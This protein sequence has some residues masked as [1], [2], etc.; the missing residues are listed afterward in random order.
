MIKNVTG[1]A[2]IGSALHR[3]VLCARL[4]DKLVSDY[5]KL[6]TLY[7]KPLMSYPYFGNIDTVSLHVL[8]SMASAIYSST[9][10]LSRHYNSEK[11]LTGVI[12]DGNY[13][14]TYMDWKYTL[15]GKT[16]AATYIKEP[17][18]EATEIELTENDM[19]YE[20]LIDTNGVRYPVTKYDP[21]WNGA[22][23]T[24]L[25][26]RNW[27]N[28]NVTD[29]SGMLGQ[30]GEVNTISLINFN[31]SN[32]TNMATMFARCLWLVTL[33]ISS[34]DTSNVVFKEDIFLENNELTT[35]IANVENIKEIV[36]KIP[37]WTTV[38]APS[39]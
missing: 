32:V 28:R 35:V 17:P 26:I 1:S 4:I 3:K 6:A 25:T 27:T 11:T 15:Y 14:F 37:T 23:I 10:E 20:S 30:L 34:F 29:M 24:T 5:N 22:P 36:P 2:Y 7:D 12:F 8:E 9:I 38:V 16:V 19:P 31:T 33:D 18:T 39:I 21:M 13:E